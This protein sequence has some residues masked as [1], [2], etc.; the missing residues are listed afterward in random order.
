MRTI[1]FI[2]FWSICWDNER[3]WT[4]LFSLMISLVPI[5]VA[6]ELL[7]LAGS[8][9]L[10]SVSVLQC[11]SVTAFINE[12]ILKPAIGAAPLDDA[13][14]ADVHAPSTSTAMALAALLVYGGRALLGSPKDALMLI[15]WAVAL[16]LTFIAKPILY[17]LSWG[18][19]AASLLPGIAVGLFWILGIERKLFEQTL[20]QI[21]QIGKFENDITGENFQEE[22]DLLP[23]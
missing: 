17:Y 22:R 10:S 14:S 2:W 7:R 20:L 9:K 16:A 21:A 12:I 3:A 19:S 6:A 13:C 23:S 11:M 5:L 4:A 15:A 8:W 18:L 1:T